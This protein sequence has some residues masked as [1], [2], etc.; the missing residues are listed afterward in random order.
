MTSARQREESL[1]EAAL[2]LPRGQRGDF[3]NR[4]CA[5]DA[6]L[7]ARIEAL[8]AGHEQTDGVLDKAN[9]A[10][11]KAPPPRPSPPS[12]NPGDRIG[13]YKLL[14]QIGEGGCGVV[15]MA[16]QETP[17][18]RRVALKIIKLGMDTRQVVARFEAERQA[19]ALMDHP[20]IAKVLDAGA[21]QTGRPFFVMELV[22]GIRITD[23]CDQNHFSTEQRLA[24]FTQVCQ[25]VQ[26]AH[27]KGIIHR[28]LKP[29][30]ILVADHDGMPVPKVIDFGIAKATTDQRLTDKTLFT[31]FEQFIGTPAYMS[32]EQANFSGLDLDT[33][34]DIYSLGVLLYE[35]LT[36]KTPFDAKALLQ[37]GLD[38]MRRTIR[39]VEPVKPSTR[40]TQELVAVDASPLRSHA[41]GARNFRAD[42]RRLLQ[43]VKGDLDWIVMKCLE[44]DRARR[45]ETANGLAL[46]VQR[47]LHKELVTARPPSAAYRF[48]KFVQRNRLAFAAA[49]VVAVT[50][51]LAFAFLLLSNARTVRERNQKDLA[52]QEK[53]VALNAAQASEQR[54]KAELFTSLKSQARARRYSRQMGQRLESLTAVT[55]ASHLRVD[56]GLRDEAI[57]ALALPDVRLGPSWPVARSDCIALTCDSMGRRY[58]MMDRQGVVTVRTIERNRES[59]R[60]ETGPACLD[61][62]TRLEFSPDG[63]YLSKVGDDQQPVV[64]SLDSGESI[65]LNAPAG[66][67]ASAF[68]PGRQLVALA[69]ATN[70]YC[71]DL[72]TG[73]ESSHWETAGRVQMVQFHPT[74]NWIAVG[75][76]QGPWVSVYEA[77]SGRVIAQLKIGDSFHTVVTW[78]PD[79]RHLAVG[80]AASGIQIW[81]LPTQ[82][83]V[84]LLKGHAQEVDFLTFHPSG[85]WLA[86]WTWD[87]V[88]D[89][90]EP[91]TGRLAMQIPLVAELQFSRDGRWLG[92]FWPDQDQAQ[93]LEFVPPE[94]Y[95]TLPDDSP[96]G[97]KVYN[98]CDLSPSGRFLTVA[99]DDGVRVWDLVEQRQIGW[100]PSGLTRSVLFG[101][102]EQTL[103]TCAEDGGLQRWALHWSGSNGSDLQ[104][105]P[106]QPTP[107]AFTPTRVTADRTTRA[108]AIVSKDAGQATILD[109][110][111]QS[112]RN[113]TVDHPVA[114]FIALSPD[115]KWLATSGWR[116]DRCRLWETANGRL[117]KDWAVSP[118]A[119]I[120]FT[121]D[122]RELIVAQGDEFR[123]LS[124]ETFEASR[125]LNR[126]IGLYPGDVAFSPDGKLMAMEMSPAVIHLK[127][128]STGRT[129]AQLEDPFGDRSDLM[130]FSRDGTKLIVLS[131]YASAIHVWDLRV[132]RSSLKAMG[133]DW[134]WP[135]FSP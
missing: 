112:L 59:R 102:D 95:S 126:E 131:P 90:W 78:H 25:A 43:E 58:A 29:S 5:G 125:R 3:L 65:L 81:D 50:M 97:R 35:L 134:D 104:F 122:S 7:R 4:A 46:D 21:T 91:T 19:L 128:T 60:F 47:Y 42:S 88:M 57:A 8:L 63:A 33:R 23:F 120:S 74:T 84:A 68:S 31:A 114:D 11:L 107:L 92:F 100:L 14:Q 85:N 135:E 36:G 116:S 103:W 130:T 89:L 117:A 61:C 51:L 98:A 87:G 13:P 6:A 48:Q 86:S 37:A 54:A 64:W 17:V 18:R 49:T 94:G 62:Y 99:M 108:L 119:R 56:A 118:P 27:Q 9:E 129:V 96:G 111:N 105:D 121:P 101:A 79:G 20:N 67:I 44:K 39:E 110:T 132:L 52:L 12:E 40:L 93:L 82:R 22:R 32:P 15:W 24:L 127:E 73:R 106:P 77:N 16:E 55:E 72:Q 123:F 53:A 10:V 26:H 2:E 133:L 30:N 66:T 28:D 76:K 83:L 70:A 75:Y 71:F 38:E 34:T 80:G 124:T 45:Y 69:S 1:F 109:L 115:A 41:E 113:F